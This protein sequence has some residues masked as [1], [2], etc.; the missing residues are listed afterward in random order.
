VTASPRT[1]AMRHRQRRGGLF[2]STCAEV[3]P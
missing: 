3:E 2:E 1:S